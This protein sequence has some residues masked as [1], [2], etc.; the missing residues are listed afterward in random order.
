MTNI[1]NSDTTVLD[2][3]PSVIRTYLA[4]HTARDVDTA[5]AAFTTEFT[6][7]TQDGPTRFDVTAHLEGDFPGGVADLLYRFDLD[8]GSIRRLVIEA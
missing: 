5:L 2:A 6:G 4:A 7:A 3:T 8:G 1:D